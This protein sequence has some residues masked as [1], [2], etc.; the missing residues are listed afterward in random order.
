MRV[1]STNETELVNAVSVL[2]DSSLAVMVTEK[3]KPATLLLPEV[4]SLNSKEVKT[5]AKAGWV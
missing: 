1:L 3:G 5:W 2:L 4:K